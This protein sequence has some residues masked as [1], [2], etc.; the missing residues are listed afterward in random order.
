MRCGLRREGE[1]EMREGER[2]IWAG[3]RAHAR[4]TDNASHYLVALIR[5]F[6]KIIGLFCKRAL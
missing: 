2:E 3:E 5:S 4:E 6:L 1:R